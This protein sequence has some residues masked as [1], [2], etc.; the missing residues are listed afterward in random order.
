MNPL[1]KVITAIILMM[2]GIHLGVLDFHLGFFLLPFHFTF[3]INLIT[4][5]NNMCLT[6]L[7]LIENR[8]VI[9]PVLDQ[10]DT[11][12]TAQVD[13]LL[14]YLQICEVQVLG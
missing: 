7:L 10:S 2:A 11:L 13:I 8:S 5:I 6:A 4:L 1:D 3:H 14:F 9:L 12:M